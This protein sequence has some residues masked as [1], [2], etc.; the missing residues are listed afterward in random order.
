MPMAV[1]DM[2]L[3]MAADSYHF[4]ISIRLYYLL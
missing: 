1:M 2:H 3:H 4:H